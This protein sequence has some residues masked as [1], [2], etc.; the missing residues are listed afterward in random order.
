MNSL[1]IRLFTL[2]EGKTLNYNKNF[3][4][5]KGTE[6]FADTYGNHTVYC[7]RKSICCFAYAC[8]FMP[9]R[10]SPCRGNP[11]QSA[12]CLVCS[13]VSPCFFLFGE[14]DVCSKLSLSGYIKTCLAR[15]YSKLC[16]F[17]S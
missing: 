1:I 12:F 7:L 15:Y 9:M 3:C 4:T 2:S 16:I 10:Q 14:L 11:Y 8:F 17:L 6:C 5:S 13:F